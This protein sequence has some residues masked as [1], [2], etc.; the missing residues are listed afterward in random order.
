MPKLS[1][2]QSIKRLAN[3]YMQSVNKRAK[4]GKEFRRSVRDIVSKD[5]ALVKKTPSTRHIAKNLEKIKGETTKSLKQKTA[6]LEKLSKNYLLDVQKRA[7]SGRALQQSVARVIAS[8]IARLEKS[9]GSANEA[10]ELLVCT[11]PEVE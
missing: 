10:L 4:S 9:G 8:D 11:H 5:I 3:E 7:T 2:K 6:E 1:G